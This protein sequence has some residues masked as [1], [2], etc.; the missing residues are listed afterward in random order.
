MLLELKLVLLLGMIGLL[1]LLSIILLLL[2]LLLSSGL[3]MMSVIDLLIVCVHHG[4]S[5]LF[6]NWTQ[7]GARIVAKCVV[8]C[9]HALA[10]I[11]SIF[12]NTL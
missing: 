3:L 9:K 7:K 10:D 12:S 8:E 1:H 5:L 2:Y 11:L 6:I 4:F